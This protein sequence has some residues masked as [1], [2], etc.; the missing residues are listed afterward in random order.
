MRAALLGLPVAVVA[1]GAN[2]QTLSPAPLPGLWET[3]MT[4]LVNGQDPAALVLQAQQAVLNL[5][6][7]AQRAQAEAMLRQHAGGLAGGKG[8]TCLTPAG[9]AAATDPKKALAMIQQHAPACRLTP[10]GTTGDALAFKGRCDDASGFS[11]DVAGH[12]TFVST[13]E[14]RWTFQG[15]GRMPAAAAIPGLNVPPDG[16][17][18]LSVQGRSRW[19][20]P[21]GC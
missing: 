18:E 5:M 1:V 13:K 20:A 9:A 15:Q 11:G 10:A 21:S 17:V 8:Q 2:A 7:A 6:P 4:R 12:L 3:E 14:T 16:S 19:L